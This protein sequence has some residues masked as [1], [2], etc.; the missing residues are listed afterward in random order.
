MKSLI[1]SF[2]VYGLA[3]AA[4][5]DTRQLDGAK[6]INTTS[7]LVSGHASSNASADVSEYLGIPFA[8]PPVGDLRFAPAVKY[9]GS[10]AINGTSFVGHSRQPT[11]LGSCWGRK[12]P[13]L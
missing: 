11:N 7:G 8:K 13:A 5:L 12:A 1:L 4:D 10:S 3:L 2:F 9:E 6:T